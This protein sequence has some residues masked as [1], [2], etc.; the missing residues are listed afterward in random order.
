MRGT[1]GTVIPIG[2][3]ERPAI[4]VSLQFPNEETRV[5]NEIID[6]IHAL[7][8][9][10]KRMGH[11]ADNAHA[12][13]GYV[14]IDKYYETVAKMITAEGLVW[15]MRET[16]YEIVIGT[17]GKANAKVT[18]KYDLYKG[19][20]SMEDY[21]QM[22]V[23]LPITGAQTTGSAVSYAEKVFMR[24][25]GCVPTGEEDA[26]AQAPEP[27][28]VPKAVEPKPIAVT[29]EQQQTVQ[30]AHDPD[31]GEIFGGDGEAPN[32]TPK[33]IADEKAVGMIEEIIKTFMPG[34]KTTAELT[35]WHAVNIAAFEKV[36]SLDPAAND[37]IKALFNDKFKELKKARK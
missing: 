1:S 28:A 10:V 15:R 8:T 5:T 31:T 30:P 13:Y 34:V 35:D 11:D 23:L 21:T 32:W 17:T 26:D 2:M 12:S 19:S 20:S 22:T 24:T 33:Q 9:K 37:R 14:S 6:A 18:Y 4:D 36:K 7:R 27:V 16:N 29:P 3:D 25:L